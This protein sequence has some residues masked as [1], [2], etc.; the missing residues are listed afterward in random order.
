LRGD[1]VARGIEHDHRE[2]INFHFLRLGEG[3]FDEGIGLLQ[4]DL[5]HAFLREGWT[6]TA[7]VQASR[8][9]DRLTGLR[10]YKGR[11]F[12]VNEARFRRLSAR[13]ALPFRAAG[14]PRPPAPVP[15]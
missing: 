14:R 15:S 1:D 12:G 3:F 5:G 4:R 9:E 11:G 10:L 7:W 2:R 8:R 13:S 6:R